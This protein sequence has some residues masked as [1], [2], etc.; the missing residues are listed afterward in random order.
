MPKRIRTI[1]GVKPKDKVA[2]RLEEGQVKVTPVKATL[3]SIYQMGGAL[4]KNLTDREITQAAWEEQVKKAA[5]K[6]L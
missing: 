2:I 6:G 4:K 1:L 3:E 5:G